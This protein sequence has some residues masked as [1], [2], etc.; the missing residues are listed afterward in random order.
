MGA[1]EERLTTTAQAEARARNQALYRMVNNRI[2]D[3]NDEFGEWDYAEFLCECGTLGCE[4][5]IRISAHEYSSV[6][7]E[8]TRFVTA[9][10]HFAPIVD[11]VVEK[12]ERYW[13]VETLPG[14]PS[15]IARKTAEPI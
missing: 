11:V 9:V 2:L 5:T 14:E 4:T 15:K 6:R 13:I 12:D 3:V 7:A 1:D 10:G 8:P